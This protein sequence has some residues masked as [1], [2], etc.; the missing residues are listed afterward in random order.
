LQAAAFLST[1]DRFTIAPM[2]LTIAAALGVSLEE[3]A[4]AAS[5]YFLLYGLMQPVWGMLSDRLGRVRVMRLALLVVVVPGL[6]SALAPNLSTLV[7]GRA[8]AGGLFAAVI[9]SALVYIG[10][11]VPI[12]GRQ[13]ALADQLA[14]SAVAT[15]IATA[16]AGLAAHFDQWRLAFALPAIASAMLGIGLARQLPEPPKV[17]GNASALA[18]IGLVARR[19]WAILVVLLALVEG[20][21][22]LGFLTYLPPS[23]EDAG[24]GAAIAGVAVGLYGLATLSWTW[25]LKWASDGLPGY[26]LIL[27]G[28]VLLVSGYTVGALNRHLAGAALAAVLVAG[29]FAFM[30]STL[31]TWATEVLPEARATVVSFFAGA[32]FAGSGVA[33]AVAAPLAE[34]GSY[35]LLFAVAA[36]TAIPLGLV[37]TI[38]RLS[39]DRK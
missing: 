18:Q 26:V 38:T 10:D 24:Y 19:P 23:L 36:L 14:A 4:V 37:G 7:V 20:G 29:G 1:F 9:P 5:V 13:K 39:Y 2:L 32:V 16:A 15:A 21:V 12:S 31:Q 35:T 30:H 25:I 34:A 33:T 6:L 11:A 27:I 17:P 8:L 22:I 3:V 28:G